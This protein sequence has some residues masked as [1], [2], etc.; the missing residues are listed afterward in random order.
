MLLVLTLLGVLLVGIGL[1]AFLFIRPSPAAGPAIPEPTS[2]IIWSLLGTL[3]LTLTIGWW[4][5]T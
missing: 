4:R 3:T 1:A 5:R 2:L